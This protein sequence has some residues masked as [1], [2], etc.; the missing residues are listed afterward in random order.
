[1]VVVP[2]WLELGERGDP[3]VCRGLLV[4]TL[5]DVSREDSSVPA[6]RDREMSLHKSLGDF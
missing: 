2:P 5:V 6:E 4:S 1:M 3:G